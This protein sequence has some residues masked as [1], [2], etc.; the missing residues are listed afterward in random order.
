[1]TERELGGYL[2]A[3]PYCVASYPF[4]PEA[5][6]F[7]VLDKMFGLIG[8]RNEK[9]AITL[10]AKPENVT[11]LSEEFQ[12]IERGY[13]MNKKHWITVTIDGEV[14]IGM[15]KEWID[16]SYE[17]VVSKLTKSERMKIKPYEC[18]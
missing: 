12:C 7:K 16:H 18:H 11:F 8:Y 2:L 1:M 17:L 3:K 4:G 9:L 10:K 14:P 15:V 6:V 5:H 13:H